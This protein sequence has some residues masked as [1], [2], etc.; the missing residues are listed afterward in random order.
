[1]PTQIFNLSP[2]ANSLNLFK[3]MSSEEDQ[4]GCIIAMQLDAQGVS[5]KSAGL[6]VSPIDCWGEG[7]PADGANVKNGSPWIVPVQ[8]CCWGRNESNEENL[9]VENNLQTVEQL[10]VTIIR[11]SEPDCSDAAYEPCEC[12]GST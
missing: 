6:D 2:G 7:E 1:M 11:T 3:D 10:S 12:G 4:V 9:Q 8:E 5:N